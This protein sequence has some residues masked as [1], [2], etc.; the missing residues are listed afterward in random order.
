LGGGA[1]KSPL[2]PFRKGGISKAYL[3]ERKRADT[4]VRP[5]EQR[6]SFKSFYP[7]GRVFSLDPGKPPEEGGHVYEEI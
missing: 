3:S 4:Q 2:P 6:N 1:K 5:Y 7:G